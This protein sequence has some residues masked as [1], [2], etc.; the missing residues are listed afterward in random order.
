M[1]PRLWTDRVGDMLDAITVARQATADVCFDE[2][3]ADRVLVQAV[4]YSFAVIGE[5]VAQVP[6]DT[7]ARYPQVPW[8][9]IRETRNIVVHVY[10]GVDLRIIWDAVQQDLPEFEA[11]L[12]QILADEERPSGP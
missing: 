7:R 8:R 9:Q 12:R 4:L 11:Q 1:P 5:A 3:V 6:A 2:F 10:F